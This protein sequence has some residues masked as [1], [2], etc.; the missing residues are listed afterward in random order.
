MLDAGDY[1]AVANALQGHAHS[2]KLLNCIYEHLHFR[3][4][5]EKEA[6]KVEP[7]L[8]H[9]TATGNRQI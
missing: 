6:A 4:H 8:R 7:N 2:A 3:R 1:T 9:S 5:S